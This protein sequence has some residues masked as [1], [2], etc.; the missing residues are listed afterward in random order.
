MAGENTLLEK[1]TVLVVDDTP[2]NLTLMSGLLKDKYKVK[3]ANNGER[4]LK[5]AMTGTPPD[6][7]LLDIMMPVMDGYEACRHL[8][9]NPETRDIPVIFLTAKAE[10]D[11]EMRGFELGAVD[12]ITKPISPPIVLARVQTQLQLKK[13]RDYLRDQN[14][15]LEAEVRRRTEEVVAIQEVTIL[16]MA[17]LAETRDNDTG[18]HIR[19]TQWY[20]KTLAENLRK[21][22]RFSHFLD[23]DKTI[24]LIFKSAPLHDIGKV[25]IPDHILLK[26]GRFTPEEF[27]IMKTHT[28]L[29]RDAIVAAERRL[30]VE[31]PFLAF[32]KEIAYSHQEKWDGSGYPEGLSG[33]DIPI[34]GRLMAV[35]DVYDALIC[36]RVYKEGMPHEK[37]VAIITEGRGSHFDPDI[38][39]AF[40]ECAD[41]FRKIA[42]LYEDTD[43]E[44]AR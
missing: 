21:N 38:V 18:N 28:T 14:E 15:F 37:A 36:R 8:K 9:E 43:E 35:A 4:A 7:I 20:I 13:V 41:E 32:A 23:D 31:M 19:R 2:D 42:K 26:P 5:V 44:L 34:S 33:D 16:A 30:G 17:S 1:P 27:E 39:D 12:Y 24:D 10:V 25:G 11:D 3:I 29:G 40:L 22:S 6:I